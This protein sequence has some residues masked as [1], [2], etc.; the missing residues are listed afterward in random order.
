MTLVLILYFTLPFLLLGFLYIFGIRSRRTLLTVSLTFLL[1][2]FLVV[3][4]LYIFR[5]PIQQGKFLADMGPL[6]SLVFPADNLYLPLATI[7]VKSEQKEYEIEFSH[8]YVGR[9]AVEISSPKGSGY[10]R[11]QQNFR[12]IL[13]VFQGGKVVYRAG[14]SRGSRFWGKDDYGL[15][16][17]TY[18]VP[19]DLPVRTELTAKVII[20]GDLDAYL[21]KHGEAFL[22]MTKMSDE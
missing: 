3:A 8:K 21:S 4:L 10:E 12:V 1:L 2:P 11:D 7:E 22:S 9:H 16:F 5:T 18:R 6:L 19:K 14:P 13:E 15:H 17:T 20:T